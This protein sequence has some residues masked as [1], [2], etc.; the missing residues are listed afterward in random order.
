MSEFNFRLLDVDLTKGETET[1]SIDRETIQ[2]FIGG[3]GL[4]AWLLWTEGPQNPD[5]LDPE[6]HLLCLSG[7]LTGTGGYIGQWTEG[8]R[9]NT[10]SL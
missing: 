10:F 8:K 1:R 4:A 3:S 2:R 9:G 7:P 6:A 5:P